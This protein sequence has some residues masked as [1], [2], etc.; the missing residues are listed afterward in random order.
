MVSVEINILLAHVC[1][2]LWFFSPHS[3]TVVCLGFPGDHLPQLAMNQS[4][5][6]KSSIT[7]TIPGPYKRHRAP[8]RQWRFRNFKTSE[9][10]CMN[11]LMIKEHN[12]SPAFRGRYFYTVLRMEVFQ[13]I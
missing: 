9:R 11:V 10:V 4:S 5:I 12:N 8:A 13:P 6:A 3:P 2:P 1:T 7:E